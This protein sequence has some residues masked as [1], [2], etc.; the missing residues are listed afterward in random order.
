M[1][2]TTHDFSEDEKQKIFYRYYNL[3]QLVYCLNSMILRKQLIRLYHLLYGT[4]KKKIEFMIAELI[5]RGFILQHQIENSRTKM[6]YLSKWPRSQF[7]AHKQTK[8]VEVLTFSKSK[9]YRHILVVDYIIQK[10]MPLMQKSSYYPISADGL[11]GFINNNTPN[12]LLSCTPYQNPIFYERFKYI[13]ECF[14]IGLDTEFERDYKIARY[15]KQY[16]KATHSKYTELPEPCKEKQELIKDMDKCQTEIQKNR[17][18]FSLNNFSAQHFIFTGIYPQKVTY[19]YIT[20]L[21]FMNAVQTQK[22]WRNLGYIYQMF[23][24]Y[25]NLKDIFLY[26][27]LWVWDSDRKD[28]LEDDFYNQKAYDFY[29]QEYST[30]KNKAHKILKDVG[31]LDSDLDNISVDF[32]VN[33][34]Y[35]KYNINLN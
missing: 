20:Y 10:I 34:I 14:N 29:R 17:M 9:L 27:D 2:H 12:L 7:N 25:T 1:N 32:T 11:M 15:D 26:V 3:I 31:I 35:E 24:R 19:F 8:D 21:D 30:Q 23:K 6:L 5:Q 28:H 13:F 16:F 18:Y 4:D 22:F 33:N